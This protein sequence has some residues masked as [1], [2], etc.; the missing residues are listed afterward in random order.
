MG[1]IKGANVFLCL[2]REVSLSQAGS[3]TFVLGAQHVSG[4]EQKI[5]VFIERKKDIAFDWREIA[6]IK[7]LV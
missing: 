5:F 4:T 6:F 3:P 1:C 7:L 2:F